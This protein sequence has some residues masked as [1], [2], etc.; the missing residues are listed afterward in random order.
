MTQPTPPGGAWGVGVATLGL[1]GHILDTWYPE[2]ALDSAEAVLGRAAELGPEAPVPGTV[3]LAGGDMARLTDL[4]LAA[5]CGVDVVRGV[6]TVVVVTFIEGLDDPPVDGH[7]VY[8][9]LHLLSHRLVAPTGSTSATCSGSL[10][11]WFG[12]RPGRARSRAS[13]AGGRPGERPGVRWWCW[14]WTGSPG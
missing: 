3:R 5:L 11:T 6:E 13:T 10:T 4:D 8:L 9:R 12:P 14:A 2:P 1:D 7:D